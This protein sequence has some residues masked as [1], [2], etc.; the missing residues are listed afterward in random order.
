MRYYE[1]KAKCGHVGKNNYYLGTIY[2]CAEDGRKAAYMVRNCPRVKH[3]KKDAIIS[4]LEISWDE[5]C[6]GNKLMHN[7]PYWMSENIQDQRQNCPNLDDFIF[8]EEK[9]EMKK[10]KKH[11]LRKN[12]NEY[13]P[14]YAEFVG[15]QGNL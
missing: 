5:W 2:V 3:D 9:G 8:R 6:E 15:Y 14:L 10:T 1:V 13:D 4:V 12:Y 7:S 11:S